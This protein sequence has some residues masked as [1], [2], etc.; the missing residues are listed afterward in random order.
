[1]NH[2]LIGDPITPPGNI[3]PISTGLPTLISNVITLATV[4]AGLLL[5]INF[6]IGG[7][8]FLTALGDPKKI[9]N[10]WTKIWQSIIGVA[11]V[12]GAIGLVSIIEKLL[13]ISILAPTI[14]GPGTI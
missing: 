7:Y 10:G 12:A 9:E 5:L 4:I 13:G 8:S 1:M 11:I 14:T 6:I 3:K 2:S